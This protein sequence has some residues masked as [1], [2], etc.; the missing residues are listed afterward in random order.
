MSTSEVQAILG[1]GEDTQDGITNNLASM[2]RL[3]QS[4][5]WKRWADPKRGDGVY[6]YI[7][8]VDDRVAHKMEFTFNIGR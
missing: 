6:Y 1:P 7:A 2:N 5:Q 4:T 3:P 8:F